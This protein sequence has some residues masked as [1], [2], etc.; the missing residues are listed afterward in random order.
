MPEEY[1]GGVGVE[2]TA[3]LK[4]WIEKGGTLVTLDRASEYATRVL[5]VPVENAVAGVPRQDFFIPG[6]LIRTEVD[7]S[8]PLAWGM[9]DTAAAYYVQ[10]LAFDP[11][12][13]A[14]EPNGAEGAK[15]AQREMDVAVRYAGDDL[16]MSGWENGAREQLGGEA[17]V[18]R[19]PMGQGTVVLTGFRTQFRAQPRGTF[20]LLFNALYSST[21]QGLPFESTHAGE[22]AVGSGDRPGMQEAAGAGGN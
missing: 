21:S 7:T 14:S 19:V 6:S 18:L 1:V 17:A 3:S 22:M 20:K 16:L 12:P 2:G 9:Q 11:V 5:G 8:D 15:M 10:S 4:R 13:P